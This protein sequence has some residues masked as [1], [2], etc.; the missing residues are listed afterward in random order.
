M[1]PT[2]RTG[3]SPPITPST[4]RLVVGLAL[5]IAALALSGCRLGVEVDLDVD[6]DAMAAV[7]IHLRLDRALVAELEELA[8]DP[9]AELGAA[10]A[11]A[12]GWELDRS[13]GDEGGVDIRL[14]RER[15]AVELV[16][17][18]LR[19]LA[20]GL[21][22]RDPAL[23]LDLEAAMGDDGRLVLAGAGGV[24]PPS[25]AGALRDGAPVGPAEDEL[26]ALIADAVDASL[27]VTAPG[28]VVTSDADAIDGSVLRWDLPVGATRDIAAVTEPVPAVGWWVTA[29]IAAVALVALIGVVAAVRRLGRRRRRWFS[30][31]A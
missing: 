1:T 3:R 29:G 12:P 19:G 6:A 25:T 10:V 5:A 8:L 4:R 28:R 7:T 9:T 23:L 20:D 21:A 24:R 22:A 15:A 11:A 17:A 26:A 16:V 27:V 31:G 18:E 2:C 30:R 13:P 14:T